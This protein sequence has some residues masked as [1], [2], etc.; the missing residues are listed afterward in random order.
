[1]VV[2]TSHVVAMAIRHRPPQSLSRPIRI[3][4]SYDR[5]TDPVAWALA[6]PDRLCP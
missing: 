5:W 2:V 4:R 6:H 1:M 3:Y